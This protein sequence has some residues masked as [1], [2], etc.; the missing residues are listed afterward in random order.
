MRQN[1][2]ALYIKSKEK[3]VEKSF[4]SLVLFALA[5]SV[6][7]SALAKKEGGGF[8]MLLHKAFPL[9]IVEHSHESSQFREKP[10][11]RLLLLVRL[12]L[13]PNQL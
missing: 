1:F 11:S 13:S 8:Q 2:F 10:S 7:H 9:L 3:V 5:T 6:V 4:S 12:L